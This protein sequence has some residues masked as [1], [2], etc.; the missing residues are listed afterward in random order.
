MVDEKPT[1]VGMVAIS[2]INYLLLEPS[3][4]VKVLCPTDIH[5]P[6]KEKVIK[7]SQLLMANKYG[8]LAAL[9]RFVWNQFVYPFYAS[10]Y[11]V[12]YSPTTHGSIFLR[13]QIITLHDLISFQFPSIHRLQRLYFK[14]ILPIFLK[15]NKKIITISKSVK[16]DILRYFPKTEPS[17]IEVIYNGYDSDLFKKNDGATTLIESEEFILAVGP[18]YAHKNFERLILAYNDLPLKTKEK[19]PLFIVSGK[20]PYLSSIKKLVDTY[21]L[22]D[23]VKFL[24]Y[25]STP[26]LSLLY[27]NGT[28]LVYLSLYEGFGLPP[29]EAM[30]CGCFVVASNTSSIPEVCGSAAY[31]VD[32]LKINEIT[33]ALKIVLES[34]SLRDEYSKRGINRVQLFQWKESFK[35]IV[36]LIIDN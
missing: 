21:E 15:K 4:D 34:P 25:V 1:G 12:A 29:I 22:Q 13:N 5:F 11:A 10:K 16:E 27:N 2:I 3:L 28:A 32:P 36:H 33:D 24:G 6:C 26:E 17:K 35:R 14:L 31:Y 30:A 8:K 7:V 23:F 20:E 9:Y 19:Y 18:T